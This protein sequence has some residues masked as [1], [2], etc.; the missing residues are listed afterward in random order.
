MRVLALPALLAVVAG[1]SALTVVAGTALVRPP[2]AHPS[3]E[4]ACLRPPLG[5]S[6]ASA[7]RV[8]RRF[9]N[10]A[11]L[12]QHTICS[13]RLVTPRVRAGLTERQWANGRIPVIPFVTADPASLV[14]SIEPHTAAD[15]ERSMWVHLESTDGEA[16]FELV[17]V[18][19][20]GRW[21]V[22]YWAPLPALSA[23]SSAQ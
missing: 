5:A 2:E 8:G 22:D 4:P 15:V 17:V 18:L 23:G 14:T 20:D 19:R 16:T 6:D 1:L 13:Y 9:V 12:R 3:A 11:V 21:L 10:T 7:A